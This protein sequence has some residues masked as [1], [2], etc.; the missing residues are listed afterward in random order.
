MW[1][2]EEPAGIGRSH[3]GER[4]NQVSRRSIFQ[5]APTGGLWKPFTYWQATINH[6][7]RVL[8]EMWCLASLMCFGHADFWL[9]FCS[10]MGWACVG[11]LCGPR[12]FPS[13]L[14]GMNTSQLTNMII[15]YDYYDILWWYVWNRKG[16]SAPVLL[17][18]WR[19]FFL[20]HA[21]MSCRGDSAKIFMQQKSC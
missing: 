19:V 1:G 15:Y 4:G 6:L 3:R 11:L 2:H 20:L 7:L 21:A 9:L 10:G 12:D 8:V 14:L 16:S 5:F 13:S 18:A 17:I